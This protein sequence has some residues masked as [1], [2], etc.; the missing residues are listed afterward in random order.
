[1]TYSYSTFRK[2]YITDLQELGLIMTDHNP[3][4]IN[5]NDWFEYAV[6]TSMELNTNQMCG[7]FSY[8][9]HGNPVFMHFCAFEISALLLLRCCDCIFV[10][11]GES[12]KPVDAYSSR[13]TFARHI[14]SHSCICILNGVGR[15]TNI[16]EFLKQIVGDIFLGLAWP[17]SQK[18]APR[19]TKRFWIFRAN[20]LHRGR[21][22][23]RLQQHS[24]RSSSIRNGGLVNLERETNIPSATEIFRRRACPRRIPSPR[25]IASQSA[26][27]VHTGVLPV[28]VNAINAITMSRGHNA[29]CCARWRIFVHW[30]ISADSPLI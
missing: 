24:I 5:I 26:A 21:I 3:R 17:R 14:Y 18:I 11:W 4:L 28:S 7:Y 23:L 15:D 2:Q 16:L 1:M 9:F 30:P 6:W 19:S 12:A 8:G 13:I 25:P 27:F 20:H 29:N 22:H 10:A